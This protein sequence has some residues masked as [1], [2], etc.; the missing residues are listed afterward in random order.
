MAN[1][2][3]NGIDLLNNG[4]NFVKTQTKRNNHFDEGRQLDDDSDD[5][6]ESDID[7]VKQR[8]EIYVW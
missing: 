3:Q 2:H 8:F 4:N 5:D 7:K 6:K 1:E